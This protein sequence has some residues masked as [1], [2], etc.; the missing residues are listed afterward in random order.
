MKTSRKH[1]PAA[2]RGRVH[3]DD[4]CPS[5]STLMKETRGSLKLPINGEE[6]MVPSAS[7]LRCPK[8]GDIV[9]RFQDAKE[10]HEA[11]IALYRRKHE[12]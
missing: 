5:C 3:A 11:A 9:L 10:L 7:H 4:A 1:D 6:I 2:L 8:C 12:H